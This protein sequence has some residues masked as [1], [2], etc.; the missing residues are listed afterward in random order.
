MGSLLGVAHCTTNNYYL[1]PDAA[2]CGTPG[3][4]CCSN[5]SCASGAR[6]F[7]GFC[8]TPDGS[9][10]HVT[11]ASDAG[12]AS[13]SG[14]AQGAD[15][16]PGY[17]GNAGDSGNAGDAPAFQGDGTTPGP[18]ASNATCASAKAI[19]FGTALTGEDLRTAY[20]DAIGSA[21]CAGTT[22]AGGELFYRT[23]PVPAQTAIYAKVTPHGAFH[24]AMTF[25]DSCQLTCAS[26]IPNSGPD[27]V[28]ARTTTASSG[29][30]LIIGLATPASY[31][32]EPGVFDVQ[33]FAPDSGDAA[34]PNGCVTP[35]TPGFVSYPEG[36]PYG[37]S[38]L[39][40]ECN[41]T[42]QFFCA[43]G[44]LGRYSSCVGDGSSW[45][46]CDGPEDCPPGQ[47]CTWSGEQSP[48][49]GWASCVPAACDQPMPFA[50]GDC[51][52][53]IDSS[54]ICHSDADC[55]SAYPY[56]YR[57]A[58]GAGGIIGTSAGV[59]L[60]HAIPPPLDAG[61]TDGPCTIPD[62]GPANYGIAC[63]AATCTSQTDEC[64]TL[65]GGTPTCQPRDAPCRE[66]NGSMLA[67]V[68]EQCDGPEDCPF[69]ASCCAFA[70]TP[71]TG[72]PVAICGSCRGG[73]VCHTSADCPTYLPTCTPWDAGTLSLCN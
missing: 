57:S 67:S 9:F 21:G 40:S 11:S 44:C 63:G 41:A 56:C 50:G 42:W 68:V 69:G 72:G 54:C 55:S 60:C 48:G 47:A 7:A 39:T 61:V 35:Y 10:A 52:G 17:T 58:C 31:G 73:E 28:L 26:V 8:A 12:S 71:V 16:G 3:L 20:P 37:I 65:G 4:P 1:P 30:I 62:A 24:V 59:A 33:V 46:S 38:G 36:P 23:P 19:S 6:C 53:V 13:D 18:F 43:G 70:Y 22:F 66:A 64:C 34:A 32:G 45:A 25:V 27:E 2:S 51:F 49:V 15:E 14:I 5:A 29:L